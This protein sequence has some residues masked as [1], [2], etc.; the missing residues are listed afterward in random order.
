MNP[1]NQNTLYGLDGYFNELKELYDIKKLP[2]K[3]LLSGP[4]GT[5]K[6]TLS[7]HLINYILSE[8]DDLKYDVKNLT[9]NENSRCSRQIRNKSSQNL[10]TVDTLD[11]KKNIDINQIRE[12]IDFC[13]KS[14]FNDKPRFILIDNFELMNL[15]SSNAL[16]KT[17]E[18]PNDNIYF[19]IINNSQKI[20][21]TIKSRCLNFKIKLSKIECLN[22]FE[23][24]TKKKAINLFNDDLI[25]HYFSTGDLINLHNFAVINKVDLFKLSL[26]DLLIKIIDKGYYKKETLNTSLIYSFIQMYFLEN[27]K[28]N[29]NYE[30]YKKFIG[31]I[32]NIKRFNL[33]IES[34]FI[35]LR[36]QLAND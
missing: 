5:G 3:I 12:L 21:P 11:D 16:L 32:E 35:Q 18:E 25:S 6:F 31:S 29:N 28:K 30:I 23:K 2:N 26:K 17:L 19:I 1:L 33:D 10:L 7:I 27:M 22:I 4:K 34:F 9:I 20:F 13:N 36:H 14:S 8:N 15:N 24:I